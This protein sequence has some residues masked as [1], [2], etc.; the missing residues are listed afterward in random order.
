LNMATHNIVPLERLREEK[1]AR[2]LC[3]PRYKAQE[4][5]KRIKELKRLRIKTV[6]FAGEKSAFNLP[7]LGKGCVG[8]VV[9]AHRDISRIALKIRRVDAD[10]KGMS[11]EAEMLAQANAIGIGPSFIDVSEDFLLMQFIEGMLVA[12]WVM[13]LKCTDAPKRIRGVL[14]EILTQCLRLDQIGLDHGELSHAAKHIIVNAHDTPYLVDFESAS[15]ERRASN[16]TSI[17][18]YLFLGGELAKTLRSKLGEINNDVLIDALRKYKREPS[19]QKFL[20]ILQI[21]RLV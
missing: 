19:D 15:T 11:H 14:R 1:Y 20:R 6:E 5:L 3:Y 21:C 17:C 4:A 7:V 2:V 12:K 18:Q 16:V 10:R 8:I 13:N 9:I